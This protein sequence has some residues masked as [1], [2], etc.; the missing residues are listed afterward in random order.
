MI[1]LRLLREEFDATAAAIRRKVPDF[2]AGALLEADSRH[3]EL[4]RQVEELRAE[5]NALSK[6]IAKASSSEREELLSSAKELSRRLDE[7]EARLESAERRLRELWDR[8]P[9]PPHESVP[10][11]RSEEDNVVVKAKGEPPEFDFEPKDHES[12]A[13]SLGLV[14]LAR[15]AKTSGTRFVYLLREAVLLEFALVSYALEKALAAGFVPVIPP[16]LVRENAMYG[17]GFFPAERFEF[18]HVTEDDLYLV[19][20][21]EVPLAS[22]HAGE[23]LDAARLPLRYVGFSS[24]FRR[25]AGTYGRDTKGAFR[26]HQFDKVELFSFTKPEE[27]WEEHERLLAIQ[28]EIVSGLGLP[29]RVVNVCA[30]ELGASAAKKYD[31]EV[32]L[33]SERRYREATSCSNCTDFQARRLA[34]R[35]RDDSGATAFAHTLNG[36]AVACTRLIVFLLENFQRADGSIVVPE[37]LAPRVGKEVIEPVGEA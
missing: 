25:E 2:D 37:V 36:T 7:L 5:R 3:R 22:L 31:I 13:V 14:D 29:Y 12:L 21:S 35:V 26:V 34:V 16:V 23:T 27:S 33:P 10:D 28:E 1:D 4:Q 24:C 11:G 32:W 8:A 20:T 30:G 17:T 18:Y 9:N 19:G 6:R 15:G